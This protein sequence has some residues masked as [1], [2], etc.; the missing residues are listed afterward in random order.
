M[1]NGAGFVYGAVQFTKGGKDAIVLYVFGRWILEVLEFDKG[2][3]KFAG[4]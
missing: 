1:V 3:R 4:E 2:V